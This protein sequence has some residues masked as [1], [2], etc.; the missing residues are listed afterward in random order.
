[1]APA[2]LALDIDGTIDTANKAEL[3]RLQN[4]AKRL[5]IPTFINTARPQIYCQQPDRMTTRLA[6]RGKHH[7]LVSNNVPRSK[8]ENMRT[9][10]ADAAVQEASCCILIDDRPENIHGV[11]SQGFTGI[12]VNEHTG[13]QKETVDEAIETMRLC[14]ANPTMRGGMRCDSR[15]NLRLAIL[16][17]IAL[18][19]ALYFLLL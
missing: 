10:Q 7:C 9:I 17:A 18:L 1:M 16:L 15:R 12:K 5:R 2:A 11:N 6:P 8:I 14:A 4:V 3:T 19:I 13:I